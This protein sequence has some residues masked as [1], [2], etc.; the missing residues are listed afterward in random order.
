V[1]E[2]PESPPTPFRC[3]G[4]RRVIGLG[5]ADRLEVGRA[6]FRKHVTVECLGCKKAN[7]WY[8][9]RRPADPPAPPPAQAQAPPPPPGDFSGG[10]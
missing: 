9:A 7:H 10:A 4:C 8:P 6:C 2:P 5:Y 3:A 1:T